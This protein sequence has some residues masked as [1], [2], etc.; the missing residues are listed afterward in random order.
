MLLISSAS[1]F[2]SIQNVFSDTLIQ[3]WFFLENKIDDFRDDVTDISA[4]KES[5]LMMLEYR[6]CCY[7]SYPC[8][9]TSLVCFHTLFKLFWD[10]LI[11]LTKFFIQYNLTIFG[12][13]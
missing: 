13:S 3:K 4:T 2:K 8:A 9:G 11:H 5:L 7:G 10:T 12:V 6:V 1:V